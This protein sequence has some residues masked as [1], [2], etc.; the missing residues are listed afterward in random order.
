M[1]SQETLQWT[2]G[3]CGHKSLHS[4]SG[5]WT[6]KKWTAQVSTR[7]YANF[8][9]EQFVL[10]LSPLFNNKLDFLRSVSD[11]VASFEVQIRSH[12]DHFLWN[13]FTVSISCNEG[14]KGAIKHISVFW[15]SFVSTFHPTDS[16]HFFLST[17]ARE[18][19]SLPSPSGR[20]SCNKI[21]SS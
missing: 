11:L 15:L 5:I 16:L 1:S 17:Q 9:D 18:D 7:I 2:I 14:P 6:V 19:H 21:N 12:L 4:A 10:F 13:D 8:H 20:Q 3:I